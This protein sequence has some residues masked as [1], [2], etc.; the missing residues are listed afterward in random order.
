MKVKFIAEDVATMKEI[1]VEGIKRERRW[2]RVSIEEMKKLVILEDWTEVNPRE[3]N[4]KAKP[5]KGM[6][7][8]LNEDGR[9]VFHLL[10][11]GIS[12]SALSCSV[13][14]IKDK[15]EVVLELSDKNEHGILDGCHTFKVIKKSLEDA[16]VLDSQQVTLE[17]MSGVE[18]ILFD[19]ARTRNTN[20]QVKEKSLANLEGKFGFLKDALKNTPYIDDIAWVENDK[21][22]ISINYIIQVLTAFNNSLG[23]KSML[24]TY[25]GAGSCET[26]YIKE[27]D[28]HKDNQKDNIYYKL[29]PLY[30]DI[31]ELID[32]IMVE[33]PI[34]YNKNGYDS[35]RGNFGRLKGIVCKSD[36]FKLLFTPGEKRVGYKIPNAMYFPI[37]AAMR[38][39]YR[40]NEE[41]MF[42]W[43][44]NPIH[45]F[46][47]LS[48]KLITKIMGYYFDKQG[49]VNEMGKTLG[50]W[51]DTYEIVNAYLKDYLKELEII[52]LRKRIAEIENK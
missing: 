3:Q 34:V 21:G 11:K 25:S 12:I 31:F 51:I 44:V 43:I 26:H 22:N 2:I 38:Q 23:D 33:F 47:S 6:E 13:K 39:L 50:L 29:T 4:L 5:A 49:F 42:E 10:N 37:L 1:S 24:K 35:E 18:D 48:E 17:V 46:D 8:T 15:K 9:G 36:H 7:I 40:E 20:T 28:K 30:P 41:G 19:L 14:N 16:K 45:A 27:F 52:D 32:H